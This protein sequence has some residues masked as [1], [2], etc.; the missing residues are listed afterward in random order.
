MKASKTNNNSK[1]KLLISYYN[2]KKIVSHIKSLSRSPGN[3]T[4]ETA[5]NTGYIK[6]SI[7]KSIGGGNPIKK[8]N[9]IN[10]PAIDMINFNNITKGVRIAGPFSMPGTCNTK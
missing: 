6:R 3:S 7:N 5:Q 8:T 4:N 9:S 10:T 1:S 2:N